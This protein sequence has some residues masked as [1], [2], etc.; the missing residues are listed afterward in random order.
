MVEVV[1]VRLSPY[2]GD[3]VA[4]YKY[5]G[6]E[7]LAQTKKTQLLMLNCIK[8][9]FKGRSRLYHHLKEKKKKLI[10]FLRMF[11]QKHGTE[12]YFFLIDLALRKQ[13]GFFFNLPKELT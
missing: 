10:T 6:G 3:S 11:L 4:G 8:F 9:A 7:I 13:W 2:L 12:S 1:R 5:R